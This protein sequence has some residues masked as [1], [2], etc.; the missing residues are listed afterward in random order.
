MT[1]EVLAIAGGT[2]TREPHLAAILRSQAYNQVM[3][4]TVL[5]PWDVQELPGEWI[6]ALHMMAYQYP[7]MAAKR[8]EVEA[9]LARIK[10]ERGWDRKL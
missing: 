7:E 2:G 10:K 1:G 5:A 8:Q 6:D 9:A 3:G 4:G